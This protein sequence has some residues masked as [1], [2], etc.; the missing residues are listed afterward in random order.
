MR[1]GLRQHRRQ[2]LSRHLLRTKDDHLLVHRV[3]RRSDGGQLLRF[4]SL[5]NHDYLYRRQQQQFQGKTVCSGIQTEVLHDTSKILQRVFRFLAK[6]PTSA[7]RFKPEQCSRGS[8]IPRRR[9]RILQRL[10]PRRQRSQA[11]SFVISVS[12]KALPVES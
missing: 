11:A 10:S 3:T 12:K 8:R 7:Q 4:D 9:W 2:I 1:Q 6:I 5:A